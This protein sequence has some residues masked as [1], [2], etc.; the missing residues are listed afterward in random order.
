MYQAAQAMP[1]EQAT[2]EC[3]LVQIYTPDVVDGMLLLEDDGLVAGRDISADLILDDGSVSRQHCC[4]E[5]NGDGFRLRDLN[6][7]NGTRVNG[8]L[9]TVATLRSGDTIQVGGFLFKFLSAGSIE[10][11]YHETV[12][13]LMTRDALTGAVNK[14]YLSELLQREINRCI[15]HEHPLSVVMLDIDHFKSV[16]DTHGHLVGDDVLREFAS[17]IT[18]ASREDDV[19]GRYGGEEFC[20][21]LCD[22]SREE[23][24]EK[25]EA[26]RKS[27]A[28]A[29]F[30]TS[31]GELVVTA[32]FGVAQLNAE[33]AR[34]VPSDK[35]LE[36]LLHTA[37][38]RLYEA[39]RDGRNRVKG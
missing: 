31:A 24:M 5:R 19:L 10:S 8:E 38:E 4:W 26:C 27:I 3:C 2:E 6:S 7:T 36:Q 25:A 11:Q 1:L 16:N 33:A 37:D 21:M 13:S 28:E 23:A 29:H 18:T 9:V 12:Y 35:R 14:R 22:T 39:K 34:N 17:R 32:S 20:L 15:R 30:K